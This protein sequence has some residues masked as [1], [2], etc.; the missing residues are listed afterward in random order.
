MEMDL[1]F[2]KMTNSIKQF[3]LHFTLFLICA[4]GNGQNQ[5]ISGRIT[6]MGQP[7]ANV[8]VMVEESNTASSTDDLGRYQ[9]KAHKGNTLKFSFTGMKTVKIIVE[10]V[11]HI[12]NLEMEAKTVLLDEVT[13]TKKLN[14]QVELAKNYQSDRNIFNTAFHFVDTRTL[15]SKVTIIDREDLDRKNSG[16][17]ASA[18]TGFF[19]G[20]IDRSNPAG[21]KFYSL[22]SLAFGRKPQAMLFDVDGQVFSE[23]PAH[24]DFV[25]NIERIAFVEGVLAATQYGMRATGGLIIVNTKGRAFVREKDSYDPYDYE[26]RRDNFYIDDTTKIS[27]GSAPNYLEDLLK[28]TSE[29]AAIGIY[30][31]QQNVLKSIPY[32]H[33]DVCDYFLKFWNNKKVSLTILDKIIADYSDHPVVLK[34]V[35]YKYDELGELEK[36]WRVYRRILLL[37]TDYA[38]SYRDLANSFRQLGDMKSTLEMYTRYGVFGQISDKFASPST[39]DSIMLSEYKNLIAIEKDPLLDKKKS[40]HE[41]EIWGAR[42]LVEWNNSEAEFELQVIHPNKQYFTINHTISGNL[43][44]IEDEKTKGYS[45]EQIWFDYSSRGTWNINLK[46][47]GNKSYDPTYFKITLYR[48][49]G[50]PTQSK[51]IKVYRINERNRNRNV[52]RFRMKGKKSQ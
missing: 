29:K 33:L 23:F 18:V 19:M 37:R 52:L 26:K 21:P 50:L 39:I 2:N 20:R 16:D 15:S 17:F 42:V 44:R 11:T 4:V 47:L 10:D 34:A 41:K 27:K 28:A 45:S 51:E 35:A 36:S 48:D 43:P 8:N 3:F 22:R 7:L 32:Y 31:N 5:E 46:Y 9:I 24:I 1:N 13:V 49:W 40:G 25:D 38:Q 30:Q 14:S 12:L 6:Q